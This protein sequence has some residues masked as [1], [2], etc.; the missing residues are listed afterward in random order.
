MNWYEITTSGGGR[1][2]HPEDNTIII[3]AFTMMEA[4]DTFKKLKGAGCITTTGDVKKCKEIYYIF[5]KEEV[6]DKLILKR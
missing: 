2:E 3:K 4:L 1:P 5:G 6:D